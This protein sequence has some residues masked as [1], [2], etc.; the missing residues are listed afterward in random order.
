MIM[1]LGTISKVLFG[2]VYIT[3]GT[4]VASS[5]STNP[6]AGTKTFTITC[7]GSTG[8]CATLVVND[9]R[10]NDTIRSWVVNYPTTPVNKNASV[11][12]GTP[13]VMQMS[14]F[15]QYVNKTD[16]AANNSKV[17]NYVFTNN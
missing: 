11:F 8:V 16:N 7:Q 3:S 15:L 4:R 1:F 6:S 5:G 17:Y 14:G 13:L 10:P 2:T 9:G 12:T